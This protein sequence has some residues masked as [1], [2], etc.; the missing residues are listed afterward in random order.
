M[1]IA[2]S[3]WIAG[4]AALVALVGLAWYAQPFAASKSSPPYRFARVERG[5]IIAAVAATG[6]INPISIVIVGSQL[7]GQVVEILS[8]YNDIVKA[9]QM[10]ARLNT[11]QL[12]AKADAARADLAQARALAMVQEANLEKNKA[13]Q[14]KARAAMADMSAQMRRADAL[15][16]DARQTLARQEQLVTRGSAT[17]VTLQAA[18]TA[19]LTQQAAR[20]STAAQITSAAASLSSLI[21]DAQVATAQLA[22]ARASIAQREAVI[23]QIEVDIRNSEIRSPV[24]GVVVQRNIELG[25]TVAASL[26]APTL[27]LV[28]ENL[29]NM[30]IYANVDETDVGRVQP[31][32]PAPFTV[33]AFPGR[34][35]EGRVQQ[36]RLG[37]QTIQNVVIYTAVIAV[38]NPGRVLL[39]GMTAN[40]R[41]LTERKGDVLRV[42]NAAL[43][44]RPAGELGA[45]RPPQV[46]G[47]PGASPFGGLPAA[48]GQASGGA[49][50]NAG[51]QFAQFA[52]RIKTEVVLD[53]AQS[54]A[55][56][57]IF[58]AAREKARTIATSEAG[59]A[60]RRESFARFRNETAEQ[61]KALLTP[62]QQPKFEAIRADFAPTAGRGQFGRL[63]RLGADGELQA[64][65]VRLGASDGT[66]TEITDAGSLKPGDD[67][68]IGGGPRSV[69]APAAPTGP[70][71]G[72]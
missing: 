36:V 12:R 43:R 44:F 8:D 35:F 34:T 31:G 27:F 26:Q 58:A 40:L 17:E 3:A 5:D 60:Q 68:V 21:A 46:G 4:G 22:S 6:T 61:V 54:A 38:E 24:D 10:M 32:Q 67:V 53:A 57:T 33:N 39:P 45:D 41:V 64:I 25:Q 63:H 28:A 65:T 19:S 14:E 50:Q 29:D 48:G 56:D 59:P 49:N 18:R 15:V 52:Q 42:S 20:E 13:D 2:R 30:V 9:N 23:R 37:S 7:S 70:R 66:F 16:D 62:A 55:V 71:P 1:R 69:P 47:A 72:L 11:D 51:R